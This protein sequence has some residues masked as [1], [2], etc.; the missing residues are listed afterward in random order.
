MTVPAGALEVRGAL[1]AKAVWR[2][3][4][5]GRCG[6]RRGGGPRTSPERSVLRATLG[7]LLWPVTFVVIQLVT[8]A[9]YHRA[10]LYRILGARWLANPSRT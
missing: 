8:N 1:S 7:G 4:R 3:G 10:G 6:S 2:A 9:Y 5:A